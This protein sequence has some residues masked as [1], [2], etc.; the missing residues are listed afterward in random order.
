MTKTQETTPAKD[1]SQYASMAET[2][3]VKDYRKFDFLIVSGGV[4]TETVTNK[5]GEKLTKNL[6]A[7]AF[8]MH[9]ASS[10][11][12]DDDVKTENLPLP[13]M[14]IP[15]KYRMIMEHKTGAK[16]DV[17][18]LATSEFNGKQTDKVLVHRFGPK[19]EKGKQKIVETYGPMTA[20]EA[21]E[22]FKDAEGQKLLKDKVIMYSLHE[23]GLVRFAIKGTSLWEDV[24]KLKDGSDKETQAVHPVLKEYFSQFAINDPYFLYEM[25]V[26]SV[27]RD[28]ISTKYYRLTFTK[29]ARI[30]PAVET[31]VLEHLDDL[32]KYFTEMDKQT[33]EFVPTTTH[34][35]T[36]VAVEESVEE[37]MSADVPF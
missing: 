1:Y 8:K 25:N 36:P 11:S 20:K 30:A 7:T 4:K 26:N 10:E 13:M 19:D 37:D 5:E 24:T 33:A 34:P 31:V 23:G 28:H 18:V 9:I 17:K 32:H 27:Y 12:E 15:I 21:K 16:Q 35:A 14:V 22:H 2:P 29:G 6:P 3:E